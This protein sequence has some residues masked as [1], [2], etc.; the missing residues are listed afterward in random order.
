MDVK[1]PDG[2]IL[3]NVPDGTTKAQIQ[4]KLGGAAPQGA[5]QDSG[6]GMAALQGFNSAVPFGRKITSAIGAG[7]AKAGGVEDT[8]SDLYAQAEANAAATSK[9]NPKTELA[10]TIAGIG[11]SLPLGFTNAGKSVG[12][13]VGSGNLAARVAKGAMVAAPSGAI[14]GAGEA[15]SGDELGGA[16]RGAMLGAAVGGALPIVG[17]GLGALNR[18]LGKK[19]VATADDIKQVSTKSYQL[20][21]QKGGILKSSLTNK[22]L[23]DI[24]SISPQTEAGRIVSGDSPFT[25]AV[26]QISGLRDK[27]LTLKSAQ[28]VDEG[29]AD[30]VDGLLDNGRVTK[31]ARKMLDVQASFRKMISDADENMVEGGKTGFEA[32]REGQKQWSASRKLSDI[33][34]IVQRAE[35]TD[36]PATALK[37]GFRNLLLSDKRIKAFSAE[38]R[39]AIEN[40]ATSGKA[41][42]L[43]RTF[44]SRLIPIGSLVGGGPLAG[45][46]GAAASMASRGAAEAL[47]LNKANKVA[48]MIADKI[49]PTK[50]IPLVEIRKIMKLPP[51]E[52]KKLLKGN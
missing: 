34:R 5:G 21:E 43:L 47:Q 7:I 23:D 25:K 44:G 29:L 36:N 41:Q 46:A 3:R 51:A 32:W 30:L 8:F 31:Q 39:K 2:T 14:Y 16:K 4:E 19:V 35:L 18:G 50:N 45:A 33:E 26:Q 28:E 24:Q 42:D 10:G 11:T 6:A 20:A 22:F 1:L 15:K 52:A 12:N 37:T 9:A 13:F 48:E 49:V 38:E 27:P 40:V 17:A